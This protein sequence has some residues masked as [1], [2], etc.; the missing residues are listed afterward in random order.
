MSLCVSNHCGPDAAA[1]HWSIAPWGHTTTGYY[2]YVTNT[3]LGQQVADVHSSPLGIPG[4]DCGTSVLLGVRAHD[5][6][7]P[8][9]DTSPLYSTTYTTPGCGGGGGGGGDTPGTQPVGDPQGINWTLTFDDEFSGTSIDQTKWSIFGAPGPNK[10]NNGVT[11][12]QADCTQ[13]GGDLRLD[14]PGDG[15]GCDMSSAWR[16]YTGQSTGA[17]AWELGVGD[18]V[19]ARV[20][21]AAAAAN[22]NDPIANWPAFWTSGSN[23]PANGEIDIAEGLAKLTS[24]Y[25]ECNVT[26]PVVGCGNTQDTTITPQPIT[27]WGGAWHIY[28]TYRTATDDY[29]YWDGNLVAD[30]KVNDLGGLQALRFNIGNHG[31]TDPSTVLGSAGD[32]LVDWVRGYTQSK[33][34]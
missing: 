11:S 15:T 4:R 14:L 10:S 25:H 24:T 29:V 27:G 8:T 31:A 2:V 5:N 32:M 12:S 19:E 16:P 23:W 13:G 20:W 3:A 26:P 1:L 21:F 34:R 30:H 7:T 17:N 6:A 18:Y 22:P 9:P 33:G 28:G